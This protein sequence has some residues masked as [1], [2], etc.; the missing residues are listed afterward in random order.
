MD[1]SSGVIL[2]VVGV[3]GLNQLVMRVGALRARSAVFWSLQLVDVLVGSAVLVFGLPGFESM[4]VISW[5]VGL[6]VFFHVIMNNN[7]R[8]QWL[9]E[10]RQERR[11][12]ERVR[13]EALRASLRAVEE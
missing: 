8:A 12:I 1:L 11:A 9:R 7:Q 3:L 6:L 5:M 10:Q 13:A 4:K 2:A